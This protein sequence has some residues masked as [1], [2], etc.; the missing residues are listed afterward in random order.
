MALQILWGTLILMRLNNYFVVADLLCVILAVILAVSIFGK[1]ENAAF[2]M[3]WIILILAMPVLGICVYFLFGHKNAT[4]KSR[5]RFEEVDAKVFSYLKQDPAVL[6]AL[7]EKDF[8]AAN[9]CRYLWNYGHFPL[10]RNTK[11][12]YYNDSSKGLAAQ[13]EA[14]RAAKR[15]IFLEYHAIEEAIAFG[16]IKEILKERAAAGVEVRILYDDVGSF[17]FIDPGFIRRMEEIGVQCRMFNPVSLVFRTFMNNRDHRKLMIVDGH[18]GFTGGYNLADEY[19][20]I[21]HPYGYWKDSALCL[22]GEAVATMTILFLEMWNVCGETDTDFAAYLPASAPASAPAAPAPAASAET[23]AAGAALDAAP[24][25]AVP[26]PE[27]P[28]A[29]VQPYAESPLDNEYVAENVYLNLIK[30]AKHTLYITTPYL[31]I[32]DEMARELGMAA[33]RGV[34]VRIGT[35]AIP[36]KKIVFR[37]TRSYYGGLV[38]RGV[39]IYEYTPG[40]LHEKQVLCDGIM[41]TVGT[42]NFD[43]R[44]FYHHFENGVLLY[45]AKAIAFIKEDMEA[46]YAKSKEVTLDYEKTTGRTFFV[47]AILRLFSPLV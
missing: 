11:V 45:D 39:R 22:E 18:V 36:D 27:E 46:V 28:A 47:D 32:S 44:S 3:P 34:D 40:F 21:T 13:I 23:P 14:L 42:I 6:K 15:F 41:A 5:A 19:F 33:Q 17:G 31:I 20:N 7:E 1:E 8:A 35:P 16:K 12:T 10:Y 25:A 30:S 26:A 2:K 38:R 29:F 4:K 9:Q 24:A 37:M 43:Y